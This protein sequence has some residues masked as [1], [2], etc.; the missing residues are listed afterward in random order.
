MGRFSHDILVDV[1]DE[2][3]FCCSM[4]SSCPGL[5]DED[6]GNHEVEAELI[7]AGVIRRDESTPD[8]EFCSLVLY[9][10]KRVYG[11]GFIDRLNAYLE[12]K[13]EWLRTPKSSFADLYKEGLF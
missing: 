7:R 6:D 12:A 4:I 1:D 8:S 13:A 3:T 10:K 9:F 5:F 11:M 2:W